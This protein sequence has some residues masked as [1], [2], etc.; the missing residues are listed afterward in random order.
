[1]H[2]EPLPIAGAMLLTLP[3]FEDSRGY[4]KEVFSCSRYRSAGIAEEFVQD[5]VSFSRRHVIRG[6]HGDARPLGKL[7]A[8]LAGD[9]FD[10]IVDVRPGS[11]TRGQWCGV[12]LRAAEHRQIYVPPGC[13]H[14]FLALSDGVL[15]LYKQTAGYD[16]AAEIAVAF[17]DPDLAVAW[18]LDGAT[19]IVSAKDAASPSARALGLLATA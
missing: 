8:V 14:G 7:V 4:F 13:L 9:A 2:V 3:A 16:P 15:F 18:P 19:A 12:T 11:A 6:L 10:A 1:M 17:D 5:N